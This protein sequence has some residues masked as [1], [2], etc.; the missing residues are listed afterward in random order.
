[1]G[2]IC[3][4]SN[5]KEWQKWAHHKQ[6]SSVFVSCAV[7]K[8][9][10]VGCDWLWSVFCCTC[11][12]ETFTHDVNLYRCRLPQFALTLGQCGTLDFEQMQLSDQCWFVVKN[13][14]FREIQSENWTFVV[15]KR[16]SPFRFV[17][18]LLQ[19]HLASDWS[20]NNKHSRNLLWCSFTVLQEAL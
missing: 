11:N 14:F 16:A 17:R 19:C 12:W 2:I 20:R 7:Q 6:C 15:E 13:S 4:S 18:Y 1:M 8:V 9:M 5:M 3:S 10:L